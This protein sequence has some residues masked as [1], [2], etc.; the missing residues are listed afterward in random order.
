MCQKHKLQIACFR[1]LASVDQMMYGCYVYIKKTMHNDYVL[2]D[3]SVYSRE[4]M[5]CMFLVGQ[6][7]ECLGLVKKLNIGVFLDNIIWKK[8]QCLH[9]GTTN[10]ALTVRTAFSDLDNIL[11]SQQCSNSFNWTFICSYLSE[12]KPCGIVK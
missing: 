3:S 6:S 2:C 12:L 1:L 7:V 5:I 8:C 4:I 9:G 10:R 11:K